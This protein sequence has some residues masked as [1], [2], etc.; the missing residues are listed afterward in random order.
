M[1]ASAEYARKYRKKLKRRAV[2]LLGPKCVFC[3]KRKNLQCAHVKDTEINGHNARGMDR[4]YRDVINHPDAY[5]RMCQYCHHLFDV[6]RA[7]G[8]VEE[9]IPF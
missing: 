4:R 6:L 2:A 8:K 5:R 1:P 3:G 7:L 9:P